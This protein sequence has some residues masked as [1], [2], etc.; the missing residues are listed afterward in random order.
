LKPLPIGS[1]MLQYLD[2]SKRLAFLKQWKEV[3]GKK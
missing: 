1:E 3:V 2:Q